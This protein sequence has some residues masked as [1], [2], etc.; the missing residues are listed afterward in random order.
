MPGKGQADSG[1]AAGLPSFL[2]VLLRP[3]IFCFA[4]LGMLRVRMEVGMAGLLELRCLGS[5]ETLCLPRG[6]GREH[7]RRSDQLKAADSV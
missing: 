4:T 7:C 6:M 2:L 1:C 3:L 5:S